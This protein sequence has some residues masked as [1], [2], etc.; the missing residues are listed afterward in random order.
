MFVVVCAVSSSAWWSG[1][2]SAQTGI[3]E[4]DRR[5]IRLFDFEDIDDRG[6]KIALG[7]RMPEHW[8]PIGRDLLEGDPRFLQQP[9]HQALERREG[10]ADHAVVGFGNDQSTSGDFSLRLDVDGGHSGV[11]LEMGVLSAVPGADYAVSA[12]VRTAGLVRSGVRL[13]AYFVDSAGL[14]IEESV[15]VS[16]DPVRTLGEWQ[17]LEVR[18]PGN[19]AKAAWVMVEAEVVQPQAHADHPLGPSQVVLRDLGGNAWI[20]DIA[21]WRLPRVEVSTQS[22]LGVV[23]APDRPEFRVAVQDLIRGN[24]T[25][26]VTVYDHALQPVATLRRPVGAGEPSSWSWSPELPGYGW[27][28]ADLQVQEAAVGSSRERLVARS[29]GAVL[30]LGPEQIMPYADRTRFTLWADRME[31][32][33]WPLLAPLTRA[34]GL[35]SVAASAWRPGLTLEGMDQWLADLDA[36]LLKPLLEDGGEVTLSLG[37]VPAKLAEAAGMETPSPLDVLALSPRVWQPFTQ[38]VLMRHGQRVRLWQLGPPGQTAALRADIANVIRQVETE[39]RATVPSPTLIIPWSLSQPRPRQVANDV[40]YALDWPAGVT[41]EALADQLAPWLDPPTKLR[42]HLKVPGGDALRH[43]RRITE[44]VLRVLHAWELDA[45]GLVLHQPWTRAREQR[46][47]LLPDPLLGVFSTLMHELAGRRVLGRVYLGQGLECMVL[48]GPAGGLLAAW[49]DRSEEVRPRVKLW[50]G[51]NPEEI[52]PFGNRDVIPQEGDEHVLQLDATPTLITGID[53]QVAMLRSSFVLD[54][55]FIESTQA[56]H[57]RV[58]TF[59]NPWNRTITGSFI[60]QKPEGWTI[61]P[62]HQSFSLPAGGEMRVPVRLRFPFSEIGGLHDLE[63]RFRFQADR[64]YDLR[65]LTPME[66]GLKDVDFNAT[67]TIQRNATTGEADVILTCVVTNRGA[68]ARSLFVFAS[69]KGFTRQEQV[70]SRLQ[71]GASVI[72]RLRFPS[73][74]LTLLKN[75]IRCGLRELNGPAVLNRL[76]DLGTE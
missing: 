36:T 67:A 43:D 57:E 40:A 5:L 14:R 45:G 65:L 24:M 27:Y 12:S 7:G 13:K 8:Y 41:P 38:P 52:D 18:L 53:A 61:E 3:V 10:Y 23:R 50:L 59:R 42:L 63:A 29:L 56:F 62:R 19:H 71:P 33:E 58:L 51:Q 37:P 15:S 39:V 34:T 1:R 21:I 26:R 69:L 66:L 48:D 60:I 17:S 47:A 4:A 16:G 46:V 75:P 35:R 44:L 72:R 74:G 31:S 9:V 22:Q 76:V 55:P 25:A 54:E 2:A 28:L 70:V 68:E 49:N 11:F 20:D 30:W 6:R 73:G 32:E 64:A